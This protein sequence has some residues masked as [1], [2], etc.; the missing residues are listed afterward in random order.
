MAKS[1]VSELAPKGARAFVEGPHHLFIGGERVETGNNIE[2]KNPATGDTLTEVPLAGRGDVDAAVV[3]ARP[4][5][6]GIESYRVHNAPSCS[7]PFLP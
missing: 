5:S 3:A 7:G 4:P 1:T 6:E 2:V